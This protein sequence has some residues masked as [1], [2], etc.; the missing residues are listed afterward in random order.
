MDRV[1]GWGKAGRAKRNVARLVA[2]LGALSGLALAAPIGCGQTTETAGF[3][4]GAAA[5]GTAESQ[6]GLTSAQVCLY[7]ARAGAAGTVFDAQIANKAPL[8]KNY[9]ASGTMNTGP[10]AGEE[11]QS[12]IQFDLSAIPPGPNTNIVTASLNL[13]LGVTGASGPGTLHV[14]RVTAPWDEATVSWQSFAGAFDPQIDASM[15]NDSPFLGTNLFYLVQGWVHGTIPN[16][17]ILLEQQGPN[18]TNLWTSEYSNYFSR[19]TLYVCYNVTCDPG[20]ADCNNNGADGCE[21]DLDTSAAHCGACGQ[22]C[23]VPNATA[24]CASGTCQVGSCNLGFGDCDGNAPNGCETL[25]TTNADCGG[26]GVACALPNA[27]ASCTTGTCTLTA[28]LPGSYDCDG[29]ASDG[30]EALPCANGAHCGTGAD[31]AS[32]VCMGGFCAS[33]ACTDGIQNG[34]ETALDCGGGACPPCVVGQTCGVGSDCTS[35]VCTSGVCQAPACNDGVKNGSETALDCGGSCAPCVDGLACVVNADCTSG[36]CTAGIC[37]TPACNDGVKNGGETAVDCGGGACPPCVAG[38]TC[39]AGSDCVDLV[40]S[41]NV[42]QLAN[43]TDG[44][45]NG[46]E[47]DV[48]C[49]GSCQACSTAAHCVTDVDCGSGVCVHGLCQAPTCTDGVQNGNET[50]IDCGGAC[51]IAE[52]CNGV[53]DDCNGLVDDGLGSTTCGVGACQVT[54]QNCVGGALQTCTPNAPVAEICDGLI[55]D[56]C[57]GVVDNGCNCVDG[58]TQSCYTASPATLGLGICQPGIQTCVHGQWGACTGETTP[59]AEACNGLDDDCNGLVDDGL[60]QTVCGIGE[61]Q[62]TQPNCLHGA[63]QTCVPRPPAAETCDNL[64]NDCDGVIDNNLPVI[65]CGVGECQN[66]ASTC[67]HG[68]PSSA[69]T[70]LAPSAEV[71]DGLDN[72]CDGLVDD[73]NPGGGQACSTGGAGVCAAGTTSC[74][75]GTVVCSQNQQPQAE[76]CNGVDDN[77]N[78]SIDE[79]VKSTY[80]R[81]ADGDGYGNP[82]VTTQACSPPSGYV[83]NA[84]DCNDGNANIRPGVAETCNGVDDNCNGSTDEG[85]PGGGGSCSTGQAGVC[86][87]GTRVCSGGSIQCVQNQGPTGE[88]CNGADDNCN[89]STDETCTAGMSNFAWSSNGPIAGMTCVQWYEPSDPDTWNDNYFCA[90]PG[91]A[92]GMAW[93]SNGPIAGKH[94]TQIIETAEPASHTWT[95]NYFCT[96]LPIPFHWSSG[97]PIGG[98]SCLQIVES[99]DPH[100]WNDNY[101]CLPSSCTCW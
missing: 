56:D 33:P 68:Q 39:D 55:D 87:A 85:N 83:A 59:A 11:R 70:P 3:G 21:T 54:V 88:S 61:C 76:S 28:C 16:Y 66:Y 30:C 26:C 62:N 50:G 38:K 20:F 46:S 19:P 18:T 23:S 47:T 101:L 84:S 41:G 10:I 58:H 45:Q 75:A 91:K 97:G 96:S 81:D 32:G 1:L 79:G 31:C 6:Q 86:A 77:C 98:M 7:I 5:E 63:P 44:V 65:A 15:A 9:G 100:T 51:S 92:Y 64:D 90:T 35:G 37:Q 17:G 57:D 2:G 94:C 4:G 67:V 24:A 27:T 22:A 72:D 42:C 48:D 60:G 36:V 80:Y 25:L 53:D 12:L 29:D 49:G 14:H 34:G 89:G 93:S 95:D 8:T 40:C 82:G 73:G 99:A 78:G 43:C 69:C 74:S 52:A 71:C 13:A